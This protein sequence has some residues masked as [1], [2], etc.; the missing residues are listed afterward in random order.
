[1][2]CTGQGC[3]MRGLARNYCSI[4]SSAWVNEEWVMAVK[5]T[6][7]FYRYII[8]ICWEQNYFKDAKVFCVYKGFLWIQ[9][10]DMETND[11]YW[12]KSMEKKY[13]WPVFPHSLSL[14]LSLSLLCHLILQITRR[15]SS[16]YLS[17]PAITISNSLK[18][19]HNFI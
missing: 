19:A 14:S 10:Y 2:E 8:V 12:K 11:F 18:I 13:Y 17:L 7:F 16:C 3:K 6:R 15:P 5:S 4:L 1:M 9:K